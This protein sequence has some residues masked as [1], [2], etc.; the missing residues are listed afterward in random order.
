M[1]C[2]ALVKKQS[3]FTDLELILLREL[4]Q[5]EMLDIERAWNNGKATHRFARID[6]IM[7]Y[8]DSTLTKVL[9]LVNEQIKDM[10]E[11]IPTQFRSN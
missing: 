8:I 2:K 5:R 9:T 6:I 11:L 4:L 3:I 1:T 10:D 7:P